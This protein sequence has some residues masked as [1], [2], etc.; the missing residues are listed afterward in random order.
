MLLVNPH[1][2]RVSERRLRSARQVLASFGAVEVVVSERIEELPGLLLRCKDR[3]LVVAGGDG[4]IHSVVEGLYSIGEFRSRIIGLL[5]FGTGNDVARSLAIPS[6]P[7]AAAQVIGTGA[8][9]W[10]DLIIGASGQPIVNI[11]H[12]GISVPSSRAGL[13][14]QPLLGRAA[15]TLGGLIGGLWGSPEVT[16]VTVDGKT[17]IDDE[18]LLM[19]AVCNGSSFGGGTVLCEAAAMNDGVLDVVCVPGRSLAEKIVFGFQLKSRGGAGVSRLVHVAGHQV[20][21]YRSTSHGILDG[22]LHDLD[23]D[24]HIVSSCW[25]VICPLIPSG[26]K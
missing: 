4:T 20:E 5:P 8:P 17:V 11:A 2:G 3:V 10:L 25:R 15:Y 22:E 12:A 7:V 26:P 24:L 1:A 13:R 16:S 9:R 14:L 6:E 23:A 21:I 19:I 18:C